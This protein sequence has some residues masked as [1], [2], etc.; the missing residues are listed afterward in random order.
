MLLIWQSS[1]VAYTH[2]HSHTLFEEFLKSY[3]N[4]HAHVAEFSFVN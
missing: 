2:I 1:F 3:P 4:Q